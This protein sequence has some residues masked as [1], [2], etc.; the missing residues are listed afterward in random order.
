MN[1]AQNRNFA[2]AATAAAII[3]A[4]ANAWLLLSLARLRAETR[5]TG[6]AGDAAIVSNELAKATA[7]L[8]TAAKPG[9]IRA[10]YARYDDYYDCALVGLSLPGDWPCP[11]KDGKA[12]EI[13]PEVKG[14]SYSRTHDYEYDSYALSFQGDFA[15]DTS[16]T[17]T[18][19]PGW[20]DSSNATL[21]RPARLSFRTP[22]AKP[23][24]S[25]AANCRYF[26]ASRQ[27]VRLPYTASGVTNIHVTV[28]R[29]YDNDIPLYGLS[30]GRQADNAEQIAEA[31]FPAGGT[32][33]DP[34]RTNGFIDLSAMKFE[35]KPGIYRVG[36]T[37]LPQTFNSDF[38]YDDGAYHRTSHEA[39]FAL[40][41]LA[42]QA[43][44]PQHGGKAAI[45]VTSFADGRPVAS[46]EVA[47]MTRAHQ[48]AAKGITG[49][50]GLALLD[51]SISP[52]DMATIAVAKAGRDTACLNLVG[53]NLLTHGAPL[54]NEVVDNPLALVFSER[55]LVRPGE[56]FES[57]VFAREPL[58]KGA[59]ALAGA[60][61]ELT[62]CD[63]SGDVVGRQ[64]AVTDAFGFARASWSIPANAEIGNWSVGCDIGGVTCGTLL[65]RV[66]AYRPDRI[67][68][69]IE[70]QAKEVVGL[71]EPV[72]LN[73]RATYYF[74]EPLSGGHATFRSA[75]FDAA[76]PKRWRGW[77]VG[78]PTN[79]GAV[80]WRSDLV[81]SE[82]GTFGAVFPGLAACG[83]TNSCAPVGII[84]GATVQEPGGR[85][86]S[87]SDVVVVHP[88]PDYL[89]IRQDENAPCSFDL[90][91]FPAIAGTAVPSDGRR[92]SVE[93]AR[94]RWER[95]FETGGNGQVKALWRE[96]TEP[97]KDLSRAIEVP[98]GDAIAWTGRLDYAES[99][100]PG[101]RY[102]LAAACGDRITAFEFWRVE[103]DGGGRSSS[104][105]A[106]ELT[107]SAEKFAPGDTAAV[108]FHA[109]SEMTATVVAG[110]FG[111]EFT[112]SFTA[113]QGLNRVEFT[114]PEGTL[115]ANYHVSVTLAGMDGGAERLSGTAKLAVD[116]SKSHRLVPELD[117]PGELRPG[118]KARIAVSLKDASGSPAPGL[119]RIAAID[120]GVA[121]LT[122]FHAADAYKF[123]FGIRT[124]LPFRRFDCFGA[125]F[126]DLRI[127]PDGSFGGDGFGAPLAKSM[128]DA[129]REASVKEKA[130][131]RIV[132][133]PVEVADDGTA[134]VEVEI[135]DHLGA[136]RFMA[137]AG[138]A[139]S[140]G[141][142]E[143]T[144]AVRNPISVM[145]SI[146][147][148]AS[149]GDRFMASATLFNH[150][151]GNDGWTFRASLPDGLALADG[152]REVSL[153][154]TLAAGQST[155][156]AFE[157]VA[158]PSASGPQDV[159][160]DFA[161]GEERASAVATA[162]LRPARPAETRTRYITIPKGGATIPAD[163]GDWIGDAE[164]RLTL[165][166]SP[167]A[168]ISESLAWLAGY[169]YG[170]LEQTV[171]GAFPFIVATELAQLGLIDDD[172]RR[173]ADMKIRL[174]YAEI[175]PMWRHGGDF[176][177]W[178]W[179]TDTWR[180]GSLYACHFIFEATRIGAISPAPPFL[181]RLR[182]WLVGVAADA[183][184][185]NRG[186][187]AYAA[188]VLA[189]ADDPAFA[190]PA[191]NIVEEGGNDFASFLAAAALMRG[192][193]ASEGAAA[194][195]AAVSAR[196]WEGSDADS[197]VREPGM[198]LFIAAKSGYG[199]LA[200]FLP[201]V[202]ALQSMLREDGSA[203]GTTRDNAWA[204]LGLAPFAARM[205]A[206]FA[207]GTVSAGGA[208]PTAF[209]ASARPVKF[210]RDT[211]A[212]IA[213]S[214]DGPIFACVE[215]VGIPAAPLRRD[216]PISISR[217]YLDGDGNEV[218]S[219]KRGELVTA[220]LEIRTPR[221]IND[222]VIADL[223]PGGFELEDKSFA[224]RST[225]GAYKLPE[226]ASQ[227]SGTEEI[228]DDRWL[229]F[230]RLDADDPALTPL[231]LSYRLRAVTVG[232]Y[233]VPSAAVEDMYSPDLAGRFSPESRIR[234]VE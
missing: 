45:F 222:A 99:D 35:A 231:T 130:T 106:I 37:T 143:E 16:Y 72:R 4:I 113:T 31:D 225:L 128:A 102:L 105:N 154:G 43:A 147:R 161:I 124:G 139:T 3:L 100:L 12:F 202:E 217:R 65:E 67:D 50:N 108:T 82:D 179:S 9:R 17:L 40:T 6:G 121:A 20:T 160:F 232:T 196:V 69:G 183:S 81:T 1:K 70:T 32:I 89:A 173:D 149:A 194:F 168:A 150:E 203:W 19:M 146:P 120:E 185:Q 8:E 55:E 178:P 175:L 78:T 77:N 109:P 39:F 148:F 93:L 71:A 53:D 200:A 66:A 15:P 182:R 34:R 23:T 84:F 24:F 48:T 205:G 169:P 14:L 132:V 215:T 74:G 38:E 177:M 95:Y 209:D 229:W 187:A 87:A 68:V 61:I 204:V 201:A 30:Y 86:V 64:R 140:A 57:A 170:C 98:D 198:A 13:E 36:V 92:I 228:R 216:W 107:P 208:A 25:L 42:L 7:G 223:V 192:G 118:G 159:A 172:A 195:D 212:E 101:G 188:Y 152:G 10:T 75:K 62:L 116:L 47:I 73:G 52:D 141:S 163:A 83:V 174:A 219:V 111:I 207:T 97:L 190:G 33:G 59:S 165:A 227:P 133:P 181:A 90:T 126:P 29:V 85:A 96:I 44:L 134:T 54:Q 171:S 91:F 176:G 186:D 79:A 158:G 56:E 119:V 28:S 221:P 112:D 114:I 184:P 5:E 193:F 155:N 18:I 27:M 76:A 129:N 137:V 104:P 197:R 164:S 166:G 51:F 206:G 125:I 199:N 127:L 21:E 49:E 2:I 234:I 110:A 211:A 123:F 226:G 115:S 210:A 117:I 191:R 103:G 218:T 213:I 180:Y 63:P 41:G 230:G 224:T 11:P 153:S 46:A 220:V 58:E 167:A 214:A 138:N 136:L 26:P 157:V 145:P 131:A 80:D 94:R 156:L 162:N 22:P 189:V 144:V 142:T 88:T 122:D 151:A 60:P 135:P 233:A